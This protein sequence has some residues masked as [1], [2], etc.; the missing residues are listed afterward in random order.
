MADTER[1]LLA[2]ASGAPA[3]S[4]RKRSAQI[5][6]ASQKRIEDFR[7]AN[8]NGHLELTIVDFR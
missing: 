8:S 6:T 3:I 7:R 5:T 4:V 1:W 2:A